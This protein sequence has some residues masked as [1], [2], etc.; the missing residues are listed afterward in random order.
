MQLESDCPVFNEAREAARSGVRFSPHFAPIQLC[1]AANGG[2]DY[3][4]ALVRD[5][6]A[7]TKERDELR[8]SRDA[9]LTVRLHA[10]APDP[11]PRRWT[12]ERP[13]GDVWRS[14][15]GRA[16]EQEINGYLCNSV[17]TPDGQGGFA[18]SWWLP[19]L[20]SDDLHT[21]PPLPSPAPAASEVKDDD[22]GS[23]FP[24]PMA[25]GPSDDLHIAGEKYGHGGMS[26]RD[27][28]ASKA[29]PP[30]LYILSAQD[31]KLEFAHVASDAY[32]L[33]DAM[34]LARKAVP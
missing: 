17:H 5:I 31:E 30:I 24:L 12:R 26:L 18:D 11:A 15:K 23:A 3:A 25:C 32:R 19:Q 29:M 9:L 21:L 33:A 10:I 22:G 20:S 14:S 13:S 4:R 7:L 6:A 1:S 34:L 2:H 27:F 16:L 8:A 28:M